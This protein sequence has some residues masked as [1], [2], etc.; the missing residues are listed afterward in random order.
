MRFPTLVALLAAASLASL[1][2]AIPAIAA[3]TMMALPDCL[4]KPATKPASVILACAD[5][6]FTATKLTWTGWGNT[7]A[8]AMGSA[9][10]NDCTPT[11]VAGHVHTYKIVLIAN[12]LQ[13]CPDG[14]RAY[15]K[16]TYAW[17]GRSPASRDDDPVVP[18]RCGAR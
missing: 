16:V 14:Q 15:T 18:F 11:C 5:A 2:G 3:P 10:L 1:S 7:F 9:S 17:V 6:N 12:G 4:G 8:A 13:T